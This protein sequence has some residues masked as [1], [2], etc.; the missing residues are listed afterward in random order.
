MLSNV[1]LRDVMALSKQGTYATIK[2]DEGDSVTRQCPFS[3]FP[4]A[5]KGV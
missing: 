5:N 2:G 1:L 3:P 4:K